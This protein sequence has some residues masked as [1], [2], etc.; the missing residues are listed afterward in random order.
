MQVA[1]H[2]ASPIVSAAEVINNMFAI[3]ILVVVECL[4]LGRLIL[5]PLLSRT[6]SDK[7]SSLVVEAHSIGTTR[8]TIYIHFPC[9]SNHVKFE[10]IS[11]AL[12]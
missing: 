8:N 10:S 5:E 11:I 12:N 6:Y 3:I 9:T 2:E 7:V 1:E 4:A